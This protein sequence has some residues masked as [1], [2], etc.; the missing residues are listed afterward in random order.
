MRKIVLIIGIIFT[1]TLVSCG[2]SACECLD[3]IDQ[4]YKHFGSGGIS[5]AKE[6]AECYSKF[7]PE[8]YQ[9][10]TGVNEGMKQARHAE[11]MQPLAIK[12]MKKECKN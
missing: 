5:Y 7:S 10:Y 2:P 12:E 9:K 1:T 11:K 3:K 6:V 4:K 8:P